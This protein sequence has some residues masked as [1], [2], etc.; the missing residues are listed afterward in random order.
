MTK[1]VAELSQPAG[2]ALPTGRV[3]RPGTGRKAAT[4][5]DPE[6]IAITMA[7]T[8][9]DIALERARDLVQAVRG[10][11]VEWRGQLLP[12][13][14]ICVGAAVYPEHGDTL[15]SLVDAADADCIGQKNRVATRRLSLRP[16]NRPADHRSPEGPNPAVVE[17]E[18]DR[19]PYA[20]ARDDGSVGP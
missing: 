18:P 3:R 13:L 17:R 19:Q 4:E 6:E 10:L 16:G 7:D 11:R 20:S 14:T 9:A 12:R 2:E 15:Y 1:A 8:P 5:T